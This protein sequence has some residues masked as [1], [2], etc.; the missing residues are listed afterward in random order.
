MLIHGTR[1]G[2]PARQAGVELA[3]SGKIA[4]VC[5]QTNVSHIFAL[6][7]VLESRQELTPVAIQAGQLLMRRLYGGA[8]LQMDYDS[9]PTAVFTPLEYGCVGL[10]EE[11]AVAAHGEENVEVYISYFKPLEWQVPAR[12][13]SLHPTPSLSLYQQS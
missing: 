3:P 7:D 4:A 11:E 1:G 6:G 10:S 9:V 8:S 12:P 2:W 5:E 13:T